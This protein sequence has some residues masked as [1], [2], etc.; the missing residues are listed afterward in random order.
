MYNMLCKAMAAEMAISEGV[1]VSLKE[2]CSENHVTVQITAISDDECLLHWGLSAAEDAAWQVPPAESWPE[3]TVQFDDTA[4]RSPFRYMDGE[5]RIDLRLPRVRRYGF[6]KFVLYYPSKDRWDNNDGRDYLVKL[7]ADSLS[8]Y[9]LEEIVNEMHSGHELLFRERYD[10]DPGMLVAAVSSFG[11]QYHITLAADM[12]EP[13]LLHWGVAVKSPF[14]WSLPPENIRPHGTVTVDSKAAQTPFDRRD[15]I[16]LISFS[17]PESDAPLGLFFVLR[18]P[19]DDGWLKYHGE[20]FYLPVKKADHGEFTGSP[21]LFSIASAIIKAETR[22]G[23][24]TLMHRYNLCY[25]LL[26]R[27]AGIEGLSLIFVW[28]RYSF[29]RQLDWQRNYNT[30]PSE[31]S[32]AQDRLTL[33]LAR[34]HR[35]RPQCRELVRMIMQMIGRGGDGQRIRD[36]ILQ[37][38]H[39]HRVKEVAGTFLE[40]WHQKLHNNT[41]PDDIVICEAYLAFLRSEGDTDI[42]YE[43]LHQG[44]VTPDRLRSFDRPITVDP[45]FMPHIRDGLI[46]DFENYLRLLRSVHSG[47]DIESAAADAGPFIDYRMRGPMEFIIR[48][49][50]DPGADPVTVAG[51]ITALRREIGNQ[52]GRERDE[53]SIRALSY[54]DL[55]LEDFLRV[56]VERAVR[57]DMDAGEMSLLMTALLENIYFSSADAELELCRSHWIRLMDTEI[58]DVERALHASA[59]T[60]RI[61]R[62]VASMADRCYGM[63][64]GHAEF[65]GDAFGI[66]E[67]II[68][69]F[70]EEVVRGRLGFVLS[71]LLHHYEPL[72]RA[73]ADIGDWQIISPAEAEGFIEV[74]N[75]LAEIQERSFDRPTI[76][77]ADLVKGYE[78]PPT[79]VRAVITPDL[80]DLVAHVAIR[81][82]NAGILFATCYSRKK[83]EQLKSLEGMPVRLIPDI[84]GDVSVEE[85]EGTGIRSAGRSAAG[86]ARPARHA[87]STYALTST[88]FTEESVGGKALNLRRLASRLPDWISVPASAAVPFGVFEHV[89]E[90]PLNSDVSYGY[91]DLLSSLEDASDIAKA[92][93]DVRSCVLRLKAPPEL[94]SSLRIVMEEAGLGWPDDWETAWTCIKKVWASKWND[95]AFFSRKNWGIPHDAI[96]MSVLI[97][98]VIR[99]DYAFVIHTTNPMTGDLS[100][101]YAEVVCGLGE[102]LVGNYPG[103]AYG[104]RYIKSTGKIKIVS[105]PGKSVSLIGRGFI[106]R[107]DSSGEDLAGFAGA[108]LYDSIMME[109]PKEVPVDYSQEP[110][111]WDGAYRERLFSMIARAGVEIEEIF[112]AARDIEGV[113]AGDRLHVVQSRPQV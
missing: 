25:D 99:A 42:F 93:A 55:A 29:M 74:A 110:L 86:I 43:T 83:F 98:R 40:Q 20:D 32:H 26:D 59:V 85:S 35:D 77:I 81:A 79:N 6:L 8:A 49:R 106:F 58:H 104:F 68:R 22:S 112:G 66:E 15:N 1:S 47:T 96:Y 103:R 62:A 56:T 108:G 87:F 80:V 102:T 34:I 88:E 109:R 52:L 65:L 82:R 13:L 17:L 51:H 113:I 61:A 69:L 39:R 63:F 2:G 14:Q 11:G 71:L 76:V 101:L 24:W 23:S 10:L 111:L 60:A 105:Y 67:W 64:Q 27:A 19:E 48:H 78:E 50:A 53:K 90:L 4:V 57:P 30:K 44:G 33:K 94:V 16:A 70:S 18:S 54:L 36:E 31:L 5:N 84:N 75:S 41:T 7:Y 97:Q 46:H 38:M 12:G 45:E 37:I 107:S 21:E 73:G 92:L 89:M 91:R 95:R 28:L 72:L 100:E 3:G 9:R